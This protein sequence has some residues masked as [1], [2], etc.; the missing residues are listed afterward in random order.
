MAGAASGASSRFASRGGE[1][2]KV[3]FSSCISLWMLV[4]VS[5]SR[6][7]M[8]KLPATGG[9]SDRSGVMPSKLQEFEPSSTCLSGFQI[10][11][12]LFEMKQPPSE[13]HLWGELPPGPY[14]SIVGTREPSRSGC[15]SAFRLA[16]SL[17]RRGVTI[18]SG[19]ARGIDAAAHL[20]ALAGRG[21]TLIVAPTWWERATPKANVAIFRAA[22]L[23][24]GGYLCL[25]QRDQHPFNPAYFRRNEALMALSHV[26]VLGECRFKSGAKNAMSHA[27]RLGR[28]RYVLPYVF[29]HELSEGPWEELSR[30]GALPLRSASDLMAPLAECGEFDNPRWWA[31]SQ[32]EEHVPVPAS[33]KAAPGQSAVVEAI[34]SGCTQVDDICVETGLDAA[35]VQHEVL[36]STLEGLVFEDET[37]LLRYHSARNARP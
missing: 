9:R 7:E 10:P 26:V 20:G 2:G 34:R 12:A 19:G 36:I 1:P 24:G 21:R 6:N 27:R 8:W 23:R 22:L 5:A 28:L 4:F 13:V 14:V 16:R 31:R 29:E 35:R 18:L 25:S 37:G 3:S 30:H 15:L 33:K 17:A 32:E 11:A